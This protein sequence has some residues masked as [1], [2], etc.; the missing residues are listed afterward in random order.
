LQL[1][2]TFAALAVSFYS[3]AN[4]LG[5]PVVGW[6]ADRVGTIKVMI[7]IYT[8]Q[9]VVFLVFPWVAITPFLLFLCSLLLGLGYAS[10]F[11]LFPVVVASISGTKHLGMNYG[12]VFSAFGLGAITSLIGSWLLDVTGSFDFAFL[13][14]GVATVFGLILLIVINKKFV[15]N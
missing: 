7:V 3:L 1:L 6:L 10:T 4:G 8:I 5:R 13:L 14:A 11:A 15:I 2:P 12:L 9:A